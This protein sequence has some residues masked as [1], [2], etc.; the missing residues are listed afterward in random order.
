MKVVCPKCGCINQ[1]L[2][3]VEGLFRC[4]GCGEWFA[5]SRQALPESPHGSDVAASFAVAA[6]AREPERDSSEA[7]KIR[8]TAVSLQIVAGLFALAAF[9]VAFVAVFNAV[10]SEDAGDGFIIAGAL[11]GAAVWFYLI[12][13]IVH[14]RALLAK[15]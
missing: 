8:T 3:A 2:P 14:I 4:T 12:A 1:A 13:Q 7:D 10:S 9:I 5:P 11:L 15:K 6:P